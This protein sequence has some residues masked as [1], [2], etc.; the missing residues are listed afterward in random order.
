MAVECGYEEVE[1]TAD[2]ALRAWGRDLGELL[3]HAAKGMFAL[4]DCISEGEQEPVDVSISVMAADEEMLLVEWLQELLY[5]SEREQAEFTGFEIRVGGFCT[6]DGVAHGVA[7]RVPQRGIKAAT[8][9][10]L[11]VNCGAK[12]CQATITFDV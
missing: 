3:I 10:D 1:H 9:S 8:Y 7:P 11:A 12:G 6:L 2:L 4:M 5:E